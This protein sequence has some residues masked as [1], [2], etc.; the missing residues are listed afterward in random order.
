MEQLIFFHDHI[1]IVLIVVVVVVG[2][3]LFCSMVMRRFNCGIFGGQGLETVWTVLPAIFLLFIA[4]PSLRL[5]Y[6]M[7]ELDDPGL[8][9]KAI[10]HQ[11]YWRYEYVDLDFRVYDSYM[12]PSDDKSVIRLLEVDNGIF[13][14][15]GVGVRVIV[16]SDDVIHS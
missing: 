10:G 5:L 14:P 6:M 12:V 1:I 7:E 2:Y 4:F 9:L 8:T 13:L 11:W 16:S 15:V 3:F